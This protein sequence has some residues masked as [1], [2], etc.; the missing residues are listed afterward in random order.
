MFCSISIRSTLVDPQ[1]EVLGAT[2]ICKYSLP[3]MAIHCRLGS[4]WYQEQWWPRRQH[5]PRQ[6]RLQDRA[7]IRS[8]KGTLAQSAKKDSVT[9]ATASPW[10]T[11][12]LRS[13]RANKTALPLASLGAQ[14]QKPHTCPTHPSSLGEWR[15]C[16]AVSHH[17]ELTWLHLSRFLVSCTRPSSNYSISHY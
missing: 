3:P 5:L 10:H 2:L 16:S 15:P 6:S 9:H 11:L 12:S 4:A 13:S 8:K 17:V 7:S 1:R 14:H